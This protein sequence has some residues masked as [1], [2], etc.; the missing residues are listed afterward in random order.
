[1]MRSLFLAAISTSLAAAYSGMDS[2]VAARDEF[3]K[4]KAKFAKHYKTVDEEDMRFSIFVENL[5]A[6]RATNEANPE[7]ATQ[8]VTK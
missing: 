6:A 4:F 8:G 5:G 7:H 2:S 3:E 1:M